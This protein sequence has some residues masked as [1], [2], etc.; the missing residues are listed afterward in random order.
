MV[1][2]GKT[3]THTLYCDLLFSS[4]QYILEIFPCQ[5]IQ[6][7]LSSGYK[8]FDYYNSTCFNYSYC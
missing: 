7:D 6:I 5:S 4:S 8:L 2:L 1:F 3:L